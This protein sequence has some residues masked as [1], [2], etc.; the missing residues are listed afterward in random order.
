[1]KNATKV[2]SR[3]FTKERW[4]SYSA[5]SVAE[6][7][8]GYEPS[9]DELYDAWQYLVDTGLAWQLQGWY[10][11]NAANLIESGLILPVKK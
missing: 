3:Y 1:M 2:N 9:K 7:F 5:C 11:R 10:G 8:C 4:D 6:G